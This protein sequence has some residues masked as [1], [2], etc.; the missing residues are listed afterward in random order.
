[1]FGKGL[2]A[3]VTICHNIL[4]LEKARSSKE[5]LHSVESN[6]EFL[7][8]KCIMSFR[9]NLMR[10]DKQYISLNDTGLL[11]RTKWHIYVRI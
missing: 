2:N 4:R 10:R 11:N 3:I 1:M 6:S 7:R 8:P 5:L 9:N